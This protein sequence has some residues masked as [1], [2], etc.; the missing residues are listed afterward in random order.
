MKIAIAGDLHLNKTVYKGV[1]D[2]INSQLHFRNADFMKAFDYMVDKC[3]NEIK[4]DLF[5][6]PGDVCG[7]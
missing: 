3:V 4:P 6:V 7:Y 5:V 2:R 1:M